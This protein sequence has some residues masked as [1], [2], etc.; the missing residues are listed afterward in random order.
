[1]DLWEIASSI[2]YGV[3]FASI[4][5]RMFPRDACPRTP[6]HAGQAEERCER[7][8]AF[9]AQPHGVEGDA[10]R[11]LEWTQGKNRVSTRAS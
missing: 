11:I 10:A 8:T 5:S 1:M 2:D 3:A 9:E 4:P 6:S 7:S